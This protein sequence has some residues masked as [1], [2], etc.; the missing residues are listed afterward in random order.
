[1][2]CRVGENACPWQIQ[3]SL[4]LTEGEDDETHLSVPPRPWGG[5]EY[6]AVVSVSQGCENSYPQPIQ[7][8]L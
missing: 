4:A 2:F 3:P 7:P 1:M 5:L 6:R 8:S